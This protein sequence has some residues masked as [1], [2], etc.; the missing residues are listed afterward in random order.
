MSFEPK[1]LCP[2]CGEMKHIGDFYP[3]SGRVHRCKVCHAIS[4]KSW[5]VRNK[6]TRLIVSARVRAKAKGVPCDL[7]LDVHRALIHDRIYGGRC[8]ATGLDFVLDADTMTAFSPSLH[9]VE[10]E[11]GYVY[12]NLQVVIFAFNAAIGSWGEDTFRTVA[13]AYLERK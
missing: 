10:P 8:E 2:S 11:R 9:R 6:A 12:D 3:R 5:S 4:V 13:H 7:E 1:Q